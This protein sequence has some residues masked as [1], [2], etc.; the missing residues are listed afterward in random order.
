MDIKVT[1]TDGMHKDFT[2]R[3]KYTASYALIT[4]R[5]GDRAVEVAIPWCSIQEV[6]TKL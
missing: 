6:E 2:G 4:Y 5:E 1:R 3:L